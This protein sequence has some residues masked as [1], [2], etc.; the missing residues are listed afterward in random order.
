MKQI[1]TRFFCIVLVVSNCFLAKTEELEIPG[2]WKNKPWPISHFSV[3]LGGFWA[4]NS[5]GLSAGTNKKPNSIFDFENDLGMNR[6]TISVLFNFNARFGKRN[7]V[8][9]SYYNI[10]RSASKQLQKDIVFRNF[11]YPMDSE[12]KSHLNTNIFRI[13]YGY[14]F[15]SN[16]KVEVGALVGFHVMAFGTGLELIGQT[17]DVSANNSANFTA[18]LP[19]F[20]LWATYAFHK[21][22]A[23]SSELSYFYL[24]VSSWDMIGKIFSGNL[25]LQYRLGKHWQ[26]DAG[27]TLFNVGVNL[28]RRVLQADLNWNY[29]GPTLSTGFR[30]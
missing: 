11:T 10:N 8:D 23:I 14:A 30:F 4:L 24:S 27:Y 20:G 25:T 17:L 6:N 16:P 7:R 28:D 18:P 29:H 5:T 13:S 15:I 9:F 21:N 12:V 1:Y 19:D 26:V 3:R 2:T 22:W